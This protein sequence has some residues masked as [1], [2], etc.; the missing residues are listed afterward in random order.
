M[1]LNCSDT[2]TIS[3]FGTGV[4]IEDHDLNSLAE[5]RMDSLRILAITVTAHNATNRITK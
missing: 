4:F 1:E 5:V 2:G 3:V